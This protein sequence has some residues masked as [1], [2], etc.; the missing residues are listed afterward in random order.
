MPSGFVS[1]AFWITLSCNACT[2]RGR[3]AF[4]G[5]NGTLVSPTVINRGFTSGLLTAAFARSLTEPPSPATL[6]TA[7]ARAATDP[8]PLRIGSTVIAVWNGSRNGCST[9][10]TVDLPVALMS[11][12]NGS[13]CAVGIRRGWRNWL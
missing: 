9:V 4:D 7:P 6:L 10:C 11:R 3:G 2:V 12:V 13:F 8:R 1:I 5:C